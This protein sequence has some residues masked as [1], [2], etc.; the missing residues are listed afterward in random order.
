[1]RIE[2]WQDLTAEGRRGVLARPAL[3]NDP[4]L[5]ARVAA[6]IERVRSGGDAALLELTTKL[7]RVE[8]IASGDGIARPRAINQR[9]QRRFARPR[10]H[11]GVSAAATRAALSI[12]PRRALRALWRPIESV[13]LYVP[14]GTRRCSTALMLGVPARLAAALRGSA[15]AAGE[16]PRRP[17]CSTQRA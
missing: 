6:I 4:T 8:L 16:R 9:A 2:I 17:A 10:K 11:R 14:A 12:R 5:A 7:D 15:T 13:G 1:M 3:A